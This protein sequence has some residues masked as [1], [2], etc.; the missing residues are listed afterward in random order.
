MEATKRSPIEMFT[1]TVFWR[2]VVSE[3]RRLVSSPVLVASK[4]AM[5]WS[6][7]RA[8]RSARSRATTRSPAMVNSE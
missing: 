6:I 3:A 7:S 4:K 5:S 1:L 8:K 2:T